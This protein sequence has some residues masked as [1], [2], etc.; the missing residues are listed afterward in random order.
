M[1][2]LS[3]PLNQIAFSVVDL[4]R[5]ER[6][7]REGLGFLPAG[8]SRFMMSTPLAGMVQGV[9]Q[10]AS[11][12][13]W[14]VGRNPWFQ[15]EMF[16]FRRPMARLMPTAFRP[17]DTGYTRIGV[18]VED[19]DRA[20]QQLEILGS[21]PLSPVFGQFGHRRAC[22]RNP[23]GVYV[24]VMEDDPL[25]GRTQGERPCPAAMR[26]V[27][28]STPDLDASLAYILAVSGGTREDTEIHADEHEAL[29]GLA[30]AQCKRAV[31]RCGDV[32]VEIVQY[33]DPIGKPWP[34]G[35]RI[36]DQGILNIAFG[37][38]SKRD[39]MALY[40]RAAAF[41]A[42]PNHAPIHVPGSGVVYVTDALGFS[43]EILW[44]APGLADRQW[45]FEPLPLA[46]RPKPDNYR[47][48]GTVR[49]DAPAER[50]WAVLTDHNRMGKWIGFEHVYR[51]SPGF[52]EPDGYGAERRMQG[53]PGTLVEQI[54]GEMPQ[55]EIRYRVIEGSPFIFHNGEI[56]LKGAGAQTEVAWTI[57]FRP[58]FVLMGPFFRWLMQMLLDRLLH[59][60]L[61][62]YVERSGA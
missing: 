43:V 8:G 33:L 5:T 2:A 19:F 30:G 21:L 9:K 18:H 49:I 6:W 62:P 36:A 42:V 3:A 50:V 51:A 14:L 52:P 39:H 10:A 11:C 56:S 15:I 17:C 1:I 57:R 22:V 27:T 44:M 38:R 4:R 26:T 7:F 29:W 25:A 16:Q 37:A 61:K 24:E 55:K 23:D 35:Y 41:G 48:E 34:V 54:V 20:L 60:Q 13:W 47:I 53:T 45:G 58:K 32:L 59:K 12:C 31:V 40:E 46:R 28:L